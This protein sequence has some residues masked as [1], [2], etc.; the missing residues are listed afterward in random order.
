MRM[1]DPILMEFDRECATTRKLL[2]R[3]PEAKLGWRP[4][5]KSY[6]LGSLAMHLATL[7]KWAAALEMPGFDL[8]SAPPPGEPPKAAAEILAGHDKAVR[9]AKAAIAK[10][11]DAS[12]MT[13]WALKK[14]G[15]ELF[16]MPRIAVVRSFILNHLIH[17]RGQL[18]VYLRL[19]D[20]PLPPIYGPTADENPFA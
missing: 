5:P 2:E 7:P 3:V 4:H 15:V 16:A 19:L 10:L 8:A 13:P 1:I 9:E 6:P 11:D 12:A 14:G 18:S 17:H 20:V